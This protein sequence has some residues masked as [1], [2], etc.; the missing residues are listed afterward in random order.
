MEVLR[1]GEDAAETV[2]PILF[3][4]ALHRLHRAFRFR[5]IYTKISEFLLAQRHN[6]ITKI[7]NNPGGW[8]EGETRRKWPRG[9]TTVS[10]FRQSRS[11]VGPSG[12]T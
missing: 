12:G 9:R 10:R 4:I 1:E 11:L 3:H 2:S 7:G 8:K 6:R 5:A